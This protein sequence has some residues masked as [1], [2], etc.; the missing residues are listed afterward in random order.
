MI[1]I[2]GLSDYKMLGTDTIKGNSLKKFPPAKGRILQATNTIIR[3]P[4][5]AFEIFWVD[6]EGKRRC[7]VI[8]VK[9]KEG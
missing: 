7:G 1:E 9:K 6:A 2:G 8:Q 4:S 3:K 5:N